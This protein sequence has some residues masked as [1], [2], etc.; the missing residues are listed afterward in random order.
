MAEHAH[1]VDDEEL[2]EMD[3]EDFD[4][5]DESDDEIDIRGLVG[6]GRN[7]SSDSPPP[8]KQRKA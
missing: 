4:D 3:V 6:K 2:S 5:E 7:Q 8:K 1:E